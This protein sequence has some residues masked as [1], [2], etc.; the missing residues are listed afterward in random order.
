MSFI[1]NAT[2]L[3]DLYCV[4]QL[5][6]KTNQA[7]KK[8]NQEFEDT[9][10]IKWV[11]LYSLFQFEWVLALLLELIPFGFLVPFLIKGYITLPHS[12]WH[13]LLYQMI[14]KLEMD[15][16]QNI[17]F[18]YFSKF[19]KY[20]LIPCLNVVEDCIDLVRVDELD[21]LENKVIRIKERIL[22]KIQSVEINKQKYVLKHQ[23]IKINNN[24][25]QVLSVL[26]K[27]QDN[28]KFKDYILSF[29]PQT[30]QIQFIDTISRECIH[31][32][33]LSLIN[34]NEDFCLIATYQDGDGNLELIK[35]NNSEDIN[36][37]LR[38]II[39]ILIQQ[40]EEY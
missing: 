39:E 10:L 37:W 19:M 16:Y 35:L 13:Y 30:N 1:L 4:V 9:L 29:D 34:I 15:Q 23:D 18:I 25:K 3:M 7:F 28:L 38:P 40:N 33:N 31:T 5:T 8:K 12:K 2:K 22:K 27:V 21:T 20:I 36:Q 26:A 32:R 14:E 11:L 24:N 17:F 6:W